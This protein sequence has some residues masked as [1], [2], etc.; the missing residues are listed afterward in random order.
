[1]LDNF[2]VGDWW[3]N[4][5]IGSL[6]NVLHAVKQCID[7]NC[8]IGSLEILVAALLRIARVNCRIGSLESSRK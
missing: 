5:R 2:T 7:V 6:E 8:R 1:M 3:V 4:C